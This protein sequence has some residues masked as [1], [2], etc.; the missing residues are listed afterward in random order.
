MIALRTHF[1]DEG[2]ASRNMAE[3]ERMHEIIYYKGKRSLSF[4]IFLTQYQK[5]FNIFKKEGEEML[6]EAKVWFLFRKVQHAGLCSSIDTL[7]TS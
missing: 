7:K 3:A 1:V 5:M 4:E 6:D 2:N